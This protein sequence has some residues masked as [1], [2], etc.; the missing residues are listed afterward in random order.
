MAQWCANYQSGGRNCYFTSQAQC[1]AAIS[2]A[3][4]SCSSEGPARP[5][6]A[7]SDAP[8][9]PARQTTPKKKEAVRERPAAPKRAAP[10][11]AAPAAAPSMPTAVRPSP[12]AAPAAPVA[13][14]PAPGDMAAKLAV[15]RKLILDGQYQAGIAAM[16]ALGFDDHPE[17]AT[18]I[19][20]AHGKLGRPD[21]A[22]SWYDKALATNP[23][24]LLALSFD[25][26]LHAD[27]GD[28]RRAQDNL[29]KLRKLC[30]ANC[31]EYVALQAVLAAKAR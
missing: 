26:M 11:T 27:R 30:N 14:T 25:G 22:R 29:E 2:G 21:E 8:A 28:L 6:A 19:G 20:F 9:K 18:Y 3:G 13:A 1:M 15:A 10:A 16:Q 7:R 4:G 31:N 24:H 23:N 17:I 5:A 12:A